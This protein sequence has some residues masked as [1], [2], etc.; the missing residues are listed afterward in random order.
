MEKLLKYLNDLNKDQRREF[1]LAVESSEGYLR[2]AVSRR[3]KLGAEICINIER[4]TSGL[5]KCE[6]LRPDADW[7]YLRGTSIV[8][9]T[10]VPGAL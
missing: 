8:L 2:K 9:V 10:E 4:E 1:C 6:D 7:A 3:Q 5:I